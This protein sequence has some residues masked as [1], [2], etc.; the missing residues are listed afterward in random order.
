VAALAAQLLAFA[1]RLLGGARA[2]A[3]LLLGRDAVER[4]HQRAQHELGELRLALQL[5]DDVGRSLEVDEVV[6]AL[7]LAVDLERELALVPLVEADDLRADL[8]EERQDVLLAVLVVLA[9]PLVEG[10]DHAFVGR[11]ARFGRR[12]FG[13]SGRCSSGRQTLLLHRARSREAPRESRGPDEGTR[14]FS[15]WWSGVAARRS[16]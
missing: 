15:R 16:R 10:E 12:R 1:H 6:D 13:R 2:L 3:Q 9:R 5:R 14:A 4:E 7:A 11:R 8:R